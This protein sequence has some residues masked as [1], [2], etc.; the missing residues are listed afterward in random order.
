[1]YELLIGL[2]CCLGMAGT[3]WGYLKWYKKKYNKNKDPKSLSST[4]YKTGWKFRVLLICL[5]LWMVYPVLLACGIYTSSGWMYYAPYIWLSW[6]KVAYAIGMG[7]IIGV[8][9]NAYGNSWENKPHVFCAS[10][11]AAGGALVGSVLRK[12]WYIGLIVWLAW[13]IYYVIKNRKNNKAGNPNAWG[14]YI[15]EVAFYSVPTCLA[16]YMLM[17]YFFL[18]K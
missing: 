18:A 9:L 12:E 4:F 2:F 17:N 15:E 8:A 6:A 13:Y 14:L 1:M 11:L 16:I 7:G 3:L 5:A 10:V